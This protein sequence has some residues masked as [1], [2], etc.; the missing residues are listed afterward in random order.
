MR[1]LATAGGGSEKQVGII[2]KG[3]GKKLGG[4]LKTTGKVTRGQTWMDLVQA[5]E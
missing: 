5:G 3:K 1:A 4:V 2:Q